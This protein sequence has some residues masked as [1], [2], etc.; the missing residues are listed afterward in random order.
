MK[1]QQ[2]KALT[3][4][5]TVALLSLNTAKATHLDEKMLSLV[6]PAS[7]TPQAVLDHIPAPKEGELSLNAT[8]SSTTTSS[9]TISATTLTQSQLEGLGEYI[10]NNVTF[11]GN[12]RTC[13]TCHPPIN[14]FTIDPKYIATLP[15][16]DPLFVAETNPA[17]AE[18][19]RPE[20]MRK[21]G[22]ILENVDGFDKPGVMRGVPTILG[23][24]TSLSPEDG[25]PATH[26]IGWSGDGA[27]G[28]GSLRMFAV[29]AVVQ[30]APKTLARV[31]GQDFR[32]P[33]DLELDA[34]EA[35]QLSLGRKQDPDLDN[36]VFIS[37]AVERGKALF[38]TRTE[39]GK[40]KRCHDN[41]GANSS[42]SGFNGNRDTGV[43][44]LPD[45]IARLLDPSIA[46]DGGLGT[47][48]NPKGGYGDGTFNM[49]TVVEA[50]DTAPFFHNNS[51]STIEQAV[52]FYN[53][54]VF[55]NSPGGI[56]V[57]GV[58]METSEV[59]AIAGFLRTLN[60]LENI[61]NSNQHDTQA[62][63]E[64]L[65]RGTQ[66]L[67]IASADTQDAIEVLEGTEYAFY[68]GEE[69]TLLKNALYLEQAAM[70]SLSSWERYYL[71]QYALS[72]KRQVVTMMVDP[73]S[74]AIGQYL[75]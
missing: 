23:I 75:N 18:L 68:N 45:Q 71:L 58:H 19:E 52:A 38:N 34:L 51:I 41:A 33:T 48:P 22:L 37:P 57:G 27:P 21:L 53:S 59:V 74:P 8:T 5:F 9:T 64:S 12:G 28:D 60:A 54:D 29:G 46:R 6:P 63:N 40:C 66:L 17:L 49:T 55:N 20:L 7:A 30:H 31:P 14:N 2:L 36:L 25:F 62:L 15:L 10:F 39:G 24:S 56:G 67:A 35:Y 61:R 4:V 16:T 69:I 72:I 1:V 44:D 50:A 70:R 43:E 13:A 32:L 3:A 11:E 26:S 73:G 47:T 42:T 65:I